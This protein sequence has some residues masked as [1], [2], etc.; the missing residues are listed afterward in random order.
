MN[1]GHN[2]EKCD[3]CGHYFPIFMLQQCKLCGKLLCSECQTIHDCCNQNFASL[4]QQQP[5]E[6]TFANNSSSVYQ[7]TYQSPYIPSSENQINQSL[8]YSQPIQNGYQQSFPE[9]N[10]QIQNNSWGMYQN[11]QLVC[12]GCGKTYHKTE[13]RKCRKC[14]AILCS[15]CQEEHYC[16]KRKKEGTPAVSS[17]GIT[18]N[19]ASSWNGESIYP[20]FPFS[21]KQEIP[22]EKC[23]ISAR[24]II[25]CTVVSVL[26]VGLI[27]AVIVSMTGFPSEFVGTWE[28]SDYSATITFDISKDGTG[29]I[30]MYSLPY[31]VSVDEEAYEN[32]GLT[33]YVVERTMNIHLSKVRDGVYDVYVDREIVSS[34]N[35]E[36]Y[37]SG[38]I[39]T[40]NYRLTFGILTRQSQNYLQFMDI[41]GEALQL[42]R[43]A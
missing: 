8:Q 33:G 1:N 42:K 26:I 13:L 3:S 30:V 40:N 16:K 28:Y 6:Q 17:L 36:Q 29:V 43:T 22:K 41:D 35:G 15:K 12:E 11:E 5:C 10:S 25:I 24:G 18:N 39:K 4:N 38:I 37:D 2:L 27:I 19:A 20:E 9:I 14:G 21:K 34:S 32:M 7:Q 31:L 23:L